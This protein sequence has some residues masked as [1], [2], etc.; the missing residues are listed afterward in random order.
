MPEHLVVPYA[1]TG[2]PHAG[3]ATAWVGIDYQPDTLTIQV[4]DRGQR[5][6][7]TTDPGHGRHGLTGLRERVN[8]YGGL[9]EAGPLPDRG[10]QVTARLPLSAAA[11]EAGGT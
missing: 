1:A 9:F 3:T 10:F 4:T 5:R 8:I 7:A 2:S 6:P 11:D